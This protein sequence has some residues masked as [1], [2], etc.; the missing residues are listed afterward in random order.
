MGMQLKPSKCRSFSIK[1]GK[2]SVVPFHI[3][4]QPIP[5][6]AHEEQK[7]LGKVIFFSG[8]SKD[9]LAYF[10]ETLG[11]KLKYIENTKIR[12]KNKLWIYK[13][14]FFPS[15]RFLLTIH[16]ITATDLK[17]LDMLCNRFIKSWAGVPRGGDKLNISHE[18][19][20]E[21]TND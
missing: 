11:N 19:R 17:Q 5:S 2:P 18:S 12:N 21:Y 13:N 10:K 1:S 3:G 14:Y 15:I 9:T 8:K 7:F 4:N 16:K 20:H 6:I